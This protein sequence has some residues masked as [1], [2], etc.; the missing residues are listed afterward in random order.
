[1]ADFEAEVERHLGRSFDEVRAQLEEMFDREWDEIAV[2]IET[3]SMKSERSFSEVIVD[4]VVRSERKPPVQSRVRRSVIR[5]IGKPW[6]DRANPWDRF[7]DRVPPPPPKVDTEASDLDE[8]T[9]LRPD[10]D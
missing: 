5:W 3:S 2:V 10:G 7:K 4:L 6:R 9:P 1:V 8:W